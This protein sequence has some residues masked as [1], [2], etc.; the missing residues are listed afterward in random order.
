MVEKDQNNGV[1]V[2]LNKPCYIL[3]V[4][5]DEGLARLIV[6][7]LKN[8]G[9]DVE[10]V[11]NGA[12]AVDRVVNNPVELML[13][14]YKLPDM[15]AKQIIDTLKERKVAV[16]F[17]IMTG[18][19]D[20]KIAVEMM[21]SGSR[22]YIV[23]HGEFFELLP[24][25]VKR[26]FEELQSEEKLSQANKALEESEKKYRSFV[27]NA[28]VGVYKTNLKGDVLYANKALSRIFEYKSPEEMMLDNV[29]KV[30]EN[31]NNW[32]VLI[33]ML[34]KKGEVKNFEIKVVTMTG[35]TKN[36]IISG[37]L[38]G[39]I[40]TGM[41]MDVTEKREFEKRLLQSEKLKAMGVMAAGIAHDF[42]NVLAIINGYAQLLQSGCDGNKELLSGLRTICRAVNDGTETVRRMS[43][44]NRMEKDTSKFVS[45]SMVEMVKLAVDFS[46]PKWKDLAHA[47]G[48]TYYLDLEGLDSVPNVLGRPSELRE[49]ITNM[50]NNALDA[51][52]GGGRIFFRT[53]NEDNTV[54]MSISDNGSGISKE[55]QM[56]IFDPFYST[57]GVEGSGLGMSVVYG[58]IGKHGGQIDIKS[59][60]GKGATFIISLPVATKTKHAEA[61][62]EFVNNI[63]IKAKNYRILVVDDVKEISDMLSMFLNRQGY[64][65]D[66]V[67]SGAEAINLVEKE[68]YDLLLC[69]LGMPEVSGWDMI[70]AVESLDKKPK[71]G[72]ITG[73]VDMLESLKNEDM[74]VDFVVGKPI[75]FL[76][77]SEH[78]QEALIIK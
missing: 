14:D 22:D 19:G 47:R 6:K 10:A 20:E 37:S 38:V 5:D 30:P 65:V 72:L 50:I 33:G 12:R 71:I 40:L 69:D 54:C 35:K 51:M 66:S 17:I 60:I 21:K 28:L 9:F 8:T 78:I 67:E 26:V 25:V 62:S 29:L 43:E 57:K 76:K 77:L 41:V 70:R 48:A 34:K 68:S 75:D 49:V 74:C 11:H 61:S 23:K 7:S 73:W 15:S 31:E 2:G 46:K 36:I 64:N 58:I 39:D 1:E 63:N 32:N 44:F 45:V 55:A 24:S 52:P 3:V 53:W 56:R 18:H 59:Q 16:P 4:E 42:N 27:D 13:L